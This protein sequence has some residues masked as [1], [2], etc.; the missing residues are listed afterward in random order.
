MG[1]ISHL[2]NFI[3]GV[4]DFTIVCEEDYPGFTVMSDRT[5]VFRST[6]LSRCWYYVATEIRGSEHNY[7]VEGK[8][9]TEWF[10]QMVSKGLIN[11][12]LIVEKV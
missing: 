7:S 11:P 5:P 4:K 2:K 10:H 8:S 6:N 12:C 9:S 1:I 3:L